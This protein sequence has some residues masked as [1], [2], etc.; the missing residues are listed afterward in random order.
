MRA[1]LTCRFPQ[2][3]YNGTS[4]RFW[5]NQNADAVCVYVP[6]PKGFDPQTV[7]FVAKT[8]HISLALGGEEASIFLLLFSS[9]GFF[10]QG[11]SAYQ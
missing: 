6:V 4:E 8:K 7:D 1:C 2:V 11:T 10:W 3:Y 5:W 9:R